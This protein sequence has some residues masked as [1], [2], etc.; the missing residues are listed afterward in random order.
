MGEK[1]GRLVPQGEI[2]M[3]QYLHPLGCSHVAPFSLIA[4]LTELLSPSYSIIFASLS[5][6]DGIFSADFDNWMTQRK[7]AANMFKV[8]NFKN[9]MLEAVRSKCL[10]CLDLIRDQVQ[11]DS[12]ASAATPT[13]VVDLQEYF[14]KMT[15]DTIG[16]IAFGQDLGALSGKNLEFME[17]FD[18][19]QMYVSDLFFQPGPAWLWN[20]CTPAGWRFRAK[21]KVLQQYGSSLVKEMIARELEDNNEEG[22]DADGEHEHGHKKKETILSY[23][24]Q[25]ESHESLKHDPRTVKFLADVIMNFQLAG[26][27]T[28]AQ[29][30]SWAVHLLSLHPDIQEKAY[31]E[32]QAVLGSPTAAASATFDQ[33]QRLEYMHAVVTEVLRLYPSVPKEGKWVFKDDVLPDGSHVAKGSWVLFVPYVMGRLDTL[34][35][36]AGAFKP[37]RHLNKPKPSNF[38]FTAFQGGPRICLGVN[39]AYMQL[40][41]GLALLLLSFNLAPVNG[42]KEV[43]PLQHSTTLPSQKGVRLQITLRHATAGGN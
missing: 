37:E 7:R 4:S 31:Q 32:A 39:L 18:Y 6:G 17:A 43:L 8:T 34:W 5:Q 24:L 29:A 11:A 30:F 15:L 1:G 12:P 25:K 23:F 22:E 26:R 3:R 21:T 9:S 42:G 10:K 20:C 38:I 14:F 36:D 13:S 27:D 40:Q 33:I 28:V 16:E 2:G 19:C 41:Y 35:A